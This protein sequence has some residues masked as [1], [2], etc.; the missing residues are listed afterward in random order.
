M[1]YNW[2]LQSF[3]TRWSISPGYTVVKKYNK[4]QFKSV[5]LLFEKI[6]LFVAYTDISLK[7]F[8]GKMNGFK[9]KLDYPF[10]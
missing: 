6:L 10:A 8:E 7:E 3:R 4:P 5:H 1:Q 9:T 2:L